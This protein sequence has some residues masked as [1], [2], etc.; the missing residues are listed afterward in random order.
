VWRQIR[1]CSKHRVATGWPCCS[2]FKAAGQ[3]VCAVLVSGLPGWHLPG[4]TQI[5][6]CAGKP[7]LLY[8]SQLVR[9]TWQ[10]VC[11]PQATSRLLVTAVATC[12]RGL[13]VPYLVKFTALHYLELQARSAKHPDLQHKCVSR[14]EIIPL[15]FLVITPTWCYQPAYTMPPHTHSVLA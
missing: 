13:G 14:I 8:S 6:S 12:Y 7:L 10:V 5:S 15:T 11:I 2:T 3:L 4:A 9:P 1:L